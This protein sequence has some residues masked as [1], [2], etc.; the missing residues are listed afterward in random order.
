MIAWKPAFFGLN[1]ASIGNFLSHVA[2]LVFV[3]DGLDVTHEKIGPRA[4]LVKNFSVVNVVE[5]DDA[6]FNQAFVAFV[7]REIPV[8]VEHIKKNVLRLLLDR[9]IHC[10]CVLLSVFLEG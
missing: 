3:G 10:R 4:F 6:F 9:A 2:A 7:V 5:N 1:P 8:A